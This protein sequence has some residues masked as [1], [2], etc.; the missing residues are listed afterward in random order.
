M[1]TE[2]RVSVIILTFRRPEDLA[3]ALASMSSQRIHEAF[4]VVVVDNAPD[5]SARA[6]VEA[7]A[8][9]ANYPVRYVN[10]TARGISSARN[11]GLAVARGA[12]V[13]FLDDD[14]IAETEWLETM[15]AAQRRYDADAVFGWVEPYTSG[16]APRGAD[17]FFEPLSRRFGVPSGPVPDA[18]IAK[19]GTN[20]SLFHTR[21]LRGSATFDPTFNLT[22]GE[23]S[24][25]I[26]A[27]AERGGVLVWCKEGRVRE[28]VPPDRLKLG[29]LLERRFSSGQ[30]RSRH[31]YTGPSR[32][33][34][35]LAK[36][37]AIGAAQATGG[38]LLAVPSAIVAPTFARRM[39]ATAAAGFGKVLFLD[40]FLVERYRRKPDEARRSSD[41]EPKDLTP[42]SKL[43]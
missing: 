40:M 12:I 36:W 16:P 7:F 3:K 32:S 43:R 33:Y 19:L 18:L 2:P 1:D 15:L 9:T 4:E 39:L 6:Q 13:A 11:R 24:A 29:F 38:T 34:G 30:L 22:G 25:V 5:G 31:F 8:A 35:T 14:Q 21:A 37:V 17:L 20:N 27:I 28:H 41:T 10:E 26:K 23:D 42:P